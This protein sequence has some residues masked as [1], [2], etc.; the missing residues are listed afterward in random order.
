MCYYERVYCIVRNHKLLYVDLL[1]TCYDLLIKPL[2]IM[3]K[4]IDIF[5]NRVVAGRIS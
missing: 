5:R 4:H 3:Q 2:P 1:G